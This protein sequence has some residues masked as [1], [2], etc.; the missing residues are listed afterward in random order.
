MAR[1]PIRDLVVQ[2]PRPKTTLSL[3]PSFREDAQQT[4]E[5]YI[6]T[7]TIRS[8]FETILDTV[9][10]GVGQGIWVQAEYGAGKTHFL[11]TLASLLADSSGALWEKVTDEAISRYR[12]R[13]QNTRLFPVLI[14]LRGE[15]QADALTAQSLMSFWRRA[16]ARRCKMLG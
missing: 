6:F 16:F 3:L 13:F 4:V 8:H 10:R 7:D 11:A 12:V 1:L 5:S 15:S 2:K 9:A 14:S